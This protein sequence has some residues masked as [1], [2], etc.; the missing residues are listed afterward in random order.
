MP[1]DK[2]L[3][4]AV[5]IKRFIQ[6]GGAERYALE[7][8]RRVAARHDVHVF[9]HEWS[10]RGDEK[11]TFHR[12]P[13]YV[14]KPTWFNQILFSH[15]THKA[16]G[17]GFDIVHSH[18]K[19][20]NFD[21]MTIHSPCF[22]SFLFKNKKP[23]KRILPLLAL[24]FSPRKMAW[25][26][27]EKKQFAYHHKRLFIAVSEKVKTDV[28]A[29]Y[30]LPDES[31]RIAFPGVDAGMKRRIRAG[32]DQQKSRSEYGLAQDDLVILFVGT[33]FKRKGLDALLQAL[34]LYPQSKC[35]IL[36]A[37]GGGGKMN[38]YK[39][40]AKELGLREQVVFLGLVEEVAKLYALSDA[41]ILPTLSDPWAMAP[42]EAMLYGVPAA[43]S[44]AE[45]CGAAEHIKS[46][47]AL[48]INDPRDPRK[49]AEAINKLKDPVLRAKL[50]RRGQALASKLTWEK[51][52]ERTLSTY[53]DVVQRKHAKL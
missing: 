34:S 15:L 9:S 41:I 13:R 52:T 6:T 26:G 46:G 3:K 12:I 42:L 19:V 33:E 8:T 38:R 29:N 47:E 5:L 31:F 14:T 7:V 17:N 32:T 18:E 22:R 16:V 28:Q 10:F 27:L 49:I 39:S 25:L 37:G 36:I 51:T 24:P 11:I 44:S 1:Y 53:Y 45:Y 21:V 43:V 4:V 20:P 30:P 2:R 35:R 40:L 23:W 48:I 50:S